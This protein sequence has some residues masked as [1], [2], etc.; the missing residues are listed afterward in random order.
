[1]IIQEVGVPSFFRRGQNTYDRQLLI[2]ARQL[3]E[4][5]V[6]AASGAELVIC[7]RTL[8]DHWAYT[9][10]LFPEAV[11]SPEAKQWE[12]L[13]LRWSRSYHELV[14]LPPEFPPVD[15]GIREGSQSFQAAI[16]VELL[17]LY[18]V[19]GLDPGTACG[20]VEQRV[21]YCVSRLKRRL[22]IL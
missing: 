16:D 17:R 5:A 7:D 21:D 15:D 20:S 14:R 22:R 6:A 18:A 3:E 10:V 11:G 9:R 12:A 4:E 19:A 1:L 8:I 13:V 2:L